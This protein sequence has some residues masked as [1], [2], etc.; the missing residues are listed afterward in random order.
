MTKAGSA[1]LA[2]VARRRSPRAYSESIVGFASLRVR[3]DFLAVT[4]IGVE[5]SVRRLRA[6]ADL[7]RRRNGDQRHP[8]VAAS[9]RSAISG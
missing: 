4:T 1:P 8:A 7:A 9:A 3:S 2:I 5:L 6:Q